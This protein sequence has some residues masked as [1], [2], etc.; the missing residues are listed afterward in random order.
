LKVGSFKTNAEQ[1]NKYFDEI[2]TIRSKIE[3]QERAINNAR[4]IVLRPI[5]NQERGASD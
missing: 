2:K 5:K 4:S 1:A 3:G